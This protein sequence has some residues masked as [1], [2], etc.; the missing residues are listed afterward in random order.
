MPNWS[1]VFQVLRR[2]S[3]PSSNPGAAETGNPH[4]RCIDYLCHSVE[5]QWLSR[6]VITGNTEEYVERCGEYCPVKWSF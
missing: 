4:K 5:E 3:P 6:P 2:G 1:K